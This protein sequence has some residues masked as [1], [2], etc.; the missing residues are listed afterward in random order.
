[1]TIINVSDEYAEEIIQNGWGLF[2]MEI[3]T[4]LRIYVHKD[5]PV[6]AR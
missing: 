5:I 6:W 2:I 3:G 1:M 4:T